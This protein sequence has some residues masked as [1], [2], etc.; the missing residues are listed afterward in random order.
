[1]QFFCRVKILECLDICNKKRQ[2][3]LAA[4][5]QANGSQ[6]IP[7]FLFI[8]FFQ[9]FSKEEFPAVLLAK[10]VLLIIRNI[11][12]FGPE[13][14][15][16]H[17]YCSYCKSQN[18]RPVILHTIQLLYYCA[19]IWNVL[20]VCGKRLPLECKSEGHCIYFSVFVFIWKFILHVWNIKLLKL[21]C[22]CNVR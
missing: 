10:W 8:T 13:L 9:K 14:L 17:M 7:V 12:G 1:M 21:K 19:F 16:Q 5:K 15:R 6:L 4:K 18:A 2:P 22:F 3:W 11:I 20:F